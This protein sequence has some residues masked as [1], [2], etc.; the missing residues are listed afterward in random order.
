MYAGRI[1]Y[2][3][4][5]AILSVLLACQI[6]ASGDAQVVVFYERGFPYFGANDA[7]SPRMI[8]EVLKEIGIEARLVGADAIAGGALREP[9]VR[10]LIWCYGNTFP[11]EAARAI[12]EYHQS[13]GCIV[14]TGVP[15]THPCRRDETGGRPVWRD[16]GHED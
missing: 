14:A 3:L 8:A 11:R 16:E 10:C 5:I 9:K 2:T 6:R 15:F 1:G 13:G 4:H 7:I 12:T